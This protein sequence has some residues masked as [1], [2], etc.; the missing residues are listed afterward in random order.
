M[1]RISVRRL[2]LPVAAVALFAGAGAATLAHTQTVECYFKK[3]LEY[4]DGTRICER[5]PIDCATVVL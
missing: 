3:C 2:A 4:P 1:R 5:T